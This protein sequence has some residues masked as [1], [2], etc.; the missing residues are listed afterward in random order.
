MARTHLTLAALV[1]S[2]MDGFS[3]AASRDY[4]SEIHDDVDAAVIENH[5][6]VSIVVEVPRTGS[7]DAELRAEARA[8]DAITAGVRSVLPF[9]V[10]AKIQQAKVGD[11]IALISSFVPGIPLTSAM[12]RG[13]ASLCVSIGQATAAI[14]ELPTSVA[15][16]AGLPS[17]SA[18]DARLQIREVVARARQTNMLPAPLAVRWEAAID[19]DGLW[20][21]EPVVVHGSFTADALLVQ[22][23]S[24]SGVIGWHALRVGDPARDLNW[25]VNADDDARTG[26]YDAYAGIRLQSVDPNLMHRANLYNEIDVARWL[27]HGIDKKSPAIVD[28]AIAM[29]D[30]LVTIV[31]SDRDEPIV[32]PDADVLDVNQVEDLLD[33]TP[34]YRP[35]GTIS[36]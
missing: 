21:F 34:V 5:S 25:L 30:Q 31:V 19:N 29:F 3:P 4:A 20:Q 9:E 13:R 2:A 23:D 33:E 12:L 1:S 8:L 28:D 26:V 16:S 14:H 11:G 32:E 35:L 10:P 6:G 15:T 22:G 27:L 17:M 18:M 36:D 24:V 7:A